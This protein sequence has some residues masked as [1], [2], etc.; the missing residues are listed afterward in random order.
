MQY[1]QRRKIHHIFIKLVDV[2]VNVRDGTFYVVKDNMYY[3]KYKYFFVK[4]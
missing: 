4:K 1:F 3:L 2:F